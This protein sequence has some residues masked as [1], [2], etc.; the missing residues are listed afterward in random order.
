MVDRFQK[1]C[2][3]TINGCNMYIKCHNYNKLC[4]GYEKGTNVIYSK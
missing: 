2:E 4:I 3:I 1:A